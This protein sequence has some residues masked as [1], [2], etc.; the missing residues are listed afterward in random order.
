MRYAAGGPVH[1]DQE[2]VLT[3]CE[4]LLFICQPCRGQQHD[5]CRGCDCQHRERT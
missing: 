5:G 3:T 4:Y 1:R 2:W